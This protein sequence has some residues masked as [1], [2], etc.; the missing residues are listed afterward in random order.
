MNLIRQ[1]YRQIALAIALLLLVAPVAF[2]LWRAAQRPRRTELQQ[3]LAPGI[4]YHR[5][6]QRQPQP[7]LMHL[8]RLTCG[9]R[10]G[11]ARD[12]G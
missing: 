12:A 5:W 2:Y 6:F 10:G 1:R 4:R 11:V 9:S 7:M 8:A 3:D